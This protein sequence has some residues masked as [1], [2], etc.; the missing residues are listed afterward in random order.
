VSSCT[1]KLHFDTSKR[2]TAD[3]TARIASLE[4]AQKHR[5]QEIQELDAADVLLDKQR[6]QLQSLEAKRKQASSS[7]RMLASS[8]EQ[9]QQR[10]DELQG[11]LQRCELSGNAMPAEL[12][13]DLQGA[14]QR[15]QARL[16]EQ[17]ASLEKLL[18]NLQVRLHF[19]KGVRANAVACATT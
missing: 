4:E 5:T 19:V 11:L 7:L 2:L 9:A 18:E 14:G 16:A 1:A 6:C 17:A 12:G 13:D 8:E 15:V 3:L 10:C